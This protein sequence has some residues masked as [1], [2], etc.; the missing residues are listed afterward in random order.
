MG[1][2]KK[3]GSGQETVDELKLDI[4]KLRNVVIEYCAESE[5]LNLSKEFGG[6]ADRLWRI[7]RSVA[8]G[9]NET[10]VAN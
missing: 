6:F 9:S 8:K 10:I 1:D 2:D 3:L 5:T 7:K 4:R